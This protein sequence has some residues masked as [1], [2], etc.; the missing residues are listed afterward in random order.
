MPPTTC[1]TF[2]LSNATLR[3]RALLH[4]HYHSPFLNPTSSRISSLVHVYSSH[5]L[6]LLN[7]SLSR[8]TMDCDTIFPVLIWLHAHAY[9]IFLKSI[10]ISDYCSP[11]S[12]RNYLPPLYPF[13]SR[14]L[15]YD[16]INY[17]SPARVSSRWYI[18]Y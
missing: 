5:L 10:K 18:I 11:L 4:P 14:Y 12:I 2:Y 15:F 17:P 16:S 1:S 7:I 9:L 8:T 13:P 3:S 6:P